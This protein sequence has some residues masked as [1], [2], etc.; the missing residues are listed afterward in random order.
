[1]R[2]ALLNAVE[3]LSSFTHSLRRSLSAVSRGSSF[4]PSLFLTVSFLSIV[5]TA[6]PQSSFPEVVRAV[7]FISG[8]SFGKSVAAV[9]DLTFDGITDILIG[10]PGADSA[11]VVSGIDGL[12]HAVVSGPAGSAFGT[13]VAG[14]FDANNDGTPDFAVAGR[15]SASVLGRVRI[16]SGANLAIL[17]DRTTGVLGD[18]F[19]AALAVIDD[20]TGDGVSD[21]AVG[22]PLAQN[23]AGPVGAVHI[24][25]GANGQTSAV[26]FGAAAG[27]E[28]GAAVA[29]CLDQNADGTRDF[30]VG[31]PQQ[32]GGK[33]AAYVHSS[34]TGAI[35]FTVTGTAAG[36]H[37]GTSVAGGGD[38]NGDGIGDF[39]IGSPDA[40]QNS[41]AFS[42][43]ARIH[44]G[45]N[46]AV[47]STKRG[48][49]INQR[50]GTAV[51]I[52]GSLDGDGR[53]DY[54]VGSPGASGG[55]GKVEL[56][57]GF[58]GARLRTFTGNSGSAGALGSALATVGDLTLDGFDDV[59]VGAP[60]VPGG[61]GSS[62]G[63]VSG[64]MACGA[65][66]FFALSSV[67]TLLL[68]WT[69][70]PPNNPGL[71]SIACLGAGPFDVG[72][73]LMAIAPTQISFLGQTL[74]IDPTQVLAF[75]VFGFGSFGAAFSTIDLSDPAL[76]SSPLYVQV[77]SI[78]IA[79]PFLTIQTSN[80]LVL[81]PCP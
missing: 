39:A 24:L 12:N 55:A 50:A 41:I 58:N 68:E 63:Y 34:L 36:G 11:Q 32:N 5:A 35:I 47:L 30:I 4:T 26:Y 14:G 22:C 51:A 37:L 19:G 20:V 70:G 42:G 44:S 18:G 73:V 65:D 3:K 48:T 31:A 45:S 13:A 60:G 46:G 72:A 49:V 29:P 43:M 74:L 79:V 71:G 59:L 21:I 1:M 81:A 40:A 10:I 52:V 54:V 33:G 80:G 56:F 17:A 57:A 66:D 62:G 69:P 2:R 27:A 16:Y 53:A 67:N 25:S 7:P 38:V 77:V 75:G 64:V 28:F 61:A 78:S 6:R 76:G 23:G 8:L 9:G 15:G